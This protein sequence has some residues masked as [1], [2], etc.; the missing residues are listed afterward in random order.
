MD[1]ISTRSDDQRQIGGFIGPHIEG[2]FIR[3]L[4]LMQMLMW[5]SN[6]LNY[7]AAASVPSEGSDS[8][9]I[10]SQDINL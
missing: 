10:V 4:Y 9:D 8:S 2:M 7:L 3:C 5:G 6:T 1:H